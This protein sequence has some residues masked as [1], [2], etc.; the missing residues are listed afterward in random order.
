MQHL[1]HN[2]L[3]HRDSSQHS[4]VE[5]NQ[6]KPFSKNLQSAQSVEPSSSYTD[7]GT[8]DRH[9][10][11]VSNPTT[12]NVGTVMLLSTA[13]VYL[14][15]NF[16]EKVLVRCL[17][18]TASERSFITTRVARLLQLKQSKENWD[19]IG[20]SGMQSHIAGIVKCKLKSRLNDFAVN[21]ELGVL[22]KITEPIPSV[23]FPKN[24]LTWPNS[25]ALA[26]FNFNVSKDI[27]VLLGSSIFAQ[28]ID[29]GKIVLGP[30]KPILY[31]TKFG[32]IF[33]GAIESSVAETSSICCTVTGRQIHN[34]T[35]QNSLAKFHKVEGMPN[36]KM[37]EN[38][39]TCEQMFLRSVTRDDSGRYQVHLPIP[40]KRLNDLGLS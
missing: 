2:K 39:K 23:N 33:S 19:V 6:G 20:I 17:V 7:T 12:S 37:N 9:E 31:Q 3:L 15:N 40:P 14:I 26:D 4:V 11:I 32:W 30:N 27:D 29:S 21:I 28:I 13:Q 5:K 36:I 10:R 35:F 1:Q 8:A 25:I 22:D 24:T 34:K 38:E 16:G 18:D